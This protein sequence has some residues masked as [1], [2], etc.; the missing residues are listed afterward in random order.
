MAI[1]WISCWTTR[2]ELKFTLLSPPPQSAAILRQRMSKRPNVQVHEMALGDKTGMTRF[3]LNV[4]EQTNSLLDNV[5]Q[6]PLGQIQ[7]HLAEVQ[8]QATTLD[9][10]AEKFEPQGML[11]LKADIQGAPSGYWSWVEGKLSPSA[12]RLFTQKFAFC[13]NTRAKPHSAT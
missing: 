1:R 6:S 12:L 11:L 7:M 13:R 4:G 10:W 3:Y 9:D 8:V 5:T 2:P